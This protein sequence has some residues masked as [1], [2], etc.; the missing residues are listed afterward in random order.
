MP[1]PVN[2]LE[3]RGA[4]ALAAPANQRLVE[5]GPP[6]SVY[7]TATAEQ[8]V[9]TPSSI[10]RSQEASS[11][12]SVQAAPATEIQNPLQA[13]MQADPDI[14][15]V[16][17]QIVTET[18]RRRAQ[19]LGEDNARFAYAQNSDYRRVQ[20]EVA[21]EAWDKFVAMYPEKAEKFAPGDANIQAALDRFKA[22]PEEERQ[23]RL[24]N[25]TPAS[26]DSQVG[27]STPAAE[28]AVVTDPPLSEVGESQPVIS[29]AMAIPEV[30]AISSTPNNNE[31]TTASSG[32]RLS[33]EQADRLNLRGETLAD[34]EFNR[35]YTEAKE[36]LGFDP[37]VQLNEAQKRALMNEALFR[38]RDYQEA[39]ANKPAETEVKVES[40]VVEKVRE[41][42]AF[43]A[44]YGSDIRFQEIMNSYTV[45]NSRAQIPLSSED[46]LNNVMNRFNRLLANENQV[47]FVPEATKAA[48]LVQLN[49]FKEGYYK[50][51]PVFLKIQEQLNTS[52][53]DQPLETRLDQA[54]R[55]Y[56]NR[57]R[58]NTGLEVED[59]AVTD[60]TEASV[61]GTTSAEANAEE[62]KEDDQTLQLIQELQAEVATLQDNSE[63]LEDV[64]DKLSKLMSE[65]QKLNEQRLR[66]KGAEA[67]SVNNGILMMMMGMLR[68]VIQ[69]AASGIGKNN[70][71]RT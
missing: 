58:S 18:P 66:E 40:P 50:K 24:G 60:K 9:V 65:M 49:A 19:E 11:L 21:A 39:Q 42:N 70:S 59:P 71:P 6:P 32:R 30:A 68:F 53:A 67:G 5:V 48:T 8:A 1:D 56:E 27:Q 37:N 3:T 29:Q 2:T 12:T 25:N 54:V 64:Y 36:A 47:P 17:I 69:Q 13:E 14:N 63:N 35:I 34:P 16:K 45:E 33:E 22:L 7:P 38:Y 57:L 43:L 52:Q 61:S 55:R 44:T 20:G 46:L 31:Q 23:R 15:A 41:Q 26:V 28:Q 51:D 10:V 4:I 62:V